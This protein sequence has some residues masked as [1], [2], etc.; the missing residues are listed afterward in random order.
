KPSKP[1]DISR[2][3]TLL[4]RLLTLRVQSG[5]SEES[6]SLSTSMMRRERPTRDPLSTRPRPLLAHWLITVMLVLLPSL[7][8]A[9]DIRVKA[10]TQLEVTVSVDGRFVTVYGALRDN[11]YQGLGSRTLV[12]DLHQVGGEQS[13]SADLITDENG[14]FVW[15]ETLDEGEW[16]VG[17]GFLGDRWHEA[18]DYH[19][20]THLAMVPTELSIRVPSWIPNWSQPTISVQ[21]ERAD[22]TP[23][24]PR[25]VVLR[26]VGGQDLALQ[27]DNRG[28]AEFTLPVVQ[29]IGEASLEA[30]FF[31]TENLIPSGAR[32]TTHLYNQ[33]ELRVWPTILRSRD[34]LVLNVSGHLTSDA[35]PMA[36]VAVSVILDGEDLPEGLTT[37]ADGR[38]AGAYENVELD[39]PSVDV[40]A[41]FEP[42][43]GAD[44]EARVENVQAVEV[45]GGWQR[46]LA[47]LLPYAAAILAV[48][49]LLAFV[50]VRL[51]TRLRSAL[52]SKP[53]PGRVSPGGGVRVSV[54][55]R[56]GTPEL[57]ISGR[58]LD[59]D[60]GL[61]IDGAEISA[62][63][64]S[65]STISPVRSG[66]VGGSGAFAMELN[67]KTRGLRVRRNGFV[68]LECRLKVPH[69]GEYTDFEVFLVSVRSWVRHLYREGVTGL[70]AEQRQASAWGSLTPRQIE[71]EVTAAYAAIRGRWR[72]ENEDAAFL[73]RLRETLDQG[74]KLE[75]PNDEL[76]VRSLT[77]L[78][79]EVYYSERRFGEEVVELCRGL[80]ERIVNLSRLGAAGVR[81]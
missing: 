18:T 29:E 43:P 9:V 52:A 53:K 34:G 44:P 75:L 74:E 3:K 8:W 7:S 24:G 55:A 40:G 31:G 27:T 68:T 26:A 22:R 17:I 59:A 60:T 6:V 51:S 13:V 4:K 69:H 78:F 72:D 15:S 16:E 14:R 28:R 5:E 63:E 21:L 33:A 2:I 32:V 73:E 80:I 39:A 79:E 65:D 76:L 77:L 49:V 67:P 30:D 48:I 71:A 45:P 66:A 70:L 47:G 1:S 12:L 41:R 25:D 62:L 23:V 20:H 37:D 36:G 35:G 56:K 50:L 19:Q 57:R 42:F 11:I 46:W 38:F 61:E 81:G 10:R 58:V 64:R 54:G